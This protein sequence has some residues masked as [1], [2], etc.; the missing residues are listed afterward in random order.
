MRCLKCGGQLDHHKCSVCGFDTVKDTVHFLSAQQAKTMSHLIAS[1]WDDEIH[2]SDVKHESIDAIDEERRQ[3]EERKKALLQRKKAL[4]Q[5]RKQIEMEIEA[6]QNSMQQDQSSANYSS[7]FIRKE[8]DVELAIIDWFKDSTEYP[9]AT[10]IDRFYQSLSFADGA[11]PWRSRSR[12]KELVYR[13]IEMNMEVN[14]PKDVSK[15]LRSDNKEPVTFF[16]PIDSFFSDVKQRTIACGKVLL[17]GIAVGKPVDIIL[18]D[19]DR[20]KSFITQINHGLY[21]YNGRSFAEKGDV[22]GLTLQ[23]IKQLKSTEA[24]AIVNPNANALHM[25]FSGSLNLLKKEEGG[26]NLPVFTGYKPFLRGLN[27]DTRGL[28]TFAKRDSKLD[29]L[30][31]G[32]K[33]I[34]HVELDEPIAIVPGMVFSVHEDDSVTIAKLTVT[35]TED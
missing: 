11:V 26:R 15:I 6:L 32:N 3:L 16:M 23:N 4:L 9:D 1:L 29:M 13:Y 31:P 25:E 34:V 2:K 20:L 30:R 27:K 8:F 21:S 17:G 22:V 14:T 12:I 24:Q 35:S 33:A 5:R 19:G 10:E 28:I 7:H 18:K